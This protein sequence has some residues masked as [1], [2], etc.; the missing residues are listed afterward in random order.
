[1]SPLTSKALPAPNL[2]IMSPSPV[3]HI[4]RST[5]EVP[6]K[7]MPSLESL[8]P[9]ESTITPRRTMSGRRSPQEDRAR[10]ERS[11]SA[12]GVL[13]GR[14]T[15]SRA[16]VRTQQSVSIKR[17]GSLR[18]P[19]HHENCTCSCGAHEAQRSRTSL[20]RR[21]SPARAH[22]AQRSRTSL[23]HR[24]SLTRALSFRRKKPSIDSLTPPLTAESV[25]AP[26]DHRQPPFASQGTDS[27]YSSG[28]SIVNPSSPEP[29]RMCSPAPTY[30]SDLYHPNRR[31]GS[32]INGSKAAAVMGMMQR[33]GSVR[34]RE[35]EQEGF[36]KPRI[37]STHHHHRPS[38][39]PNQQQ[40]PP[41]RLGRSPSVVS[42]SSLNRKG[43]KG[44]SLIGRTR[45]RLVS[46]LRRSKR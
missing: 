23:S 26:V 35:H 6:G 9:S 37:I 34:D 25:R 43:K 20:S 31:P 1:M 19:R 11:R 8:T 45:R 28:E 5:P 17:G 33:S 32:R 41:S 18:E 21:S 13:E 15:S 22:E 40:Q 2:R 7:S 12:M 27:A 10:E 16:S 4:D 46:L 42:T 36:G 39:A 38:T 14:G 30:T 29:D 44:P 24:S 3:E